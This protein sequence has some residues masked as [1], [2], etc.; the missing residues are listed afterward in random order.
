MPKFAGKSFRATKRAKG[1]VVRRAK[2]RFFCCKSS[3]SAG[4]ATCGA[5][6]VKQ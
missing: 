3:K 2:S 1:R 5:V 4:M 6:T